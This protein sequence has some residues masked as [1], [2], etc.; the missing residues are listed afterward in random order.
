N[1]LD[2]ARGKQRSVHNTYFTLPV[3]FAM[4]STHYATAFAHPDRGWV[5]ALFMLAAAAIRQ[6]F[7]VWHSGRRDWWLLGLGGVVLALALAWIAP[8]PSPKPAASPTADAPA[9]QDEPQAPPLQA[10]I[11]TIHAILHERCAQ[12]CHSATP[13]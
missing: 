6:F 2:G 9:V 12:A 10:D 13:T 4:L 8:R 11:A 1:P 3:V 5:L 7:V